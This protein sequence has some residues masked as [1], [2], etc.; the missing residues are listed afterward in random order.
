MTISRTSFLQRI[1]KYCADSERCTHDVLTKLEA[2]GITSDESDDILKKLY[3]EKFVNDRRYA[4]SYVEEKWN[5]DRWG[6]IKIA[7]ALQQKNL[8]EKIIHDALN[9]IDDEEYIQGL[10]EL[11]LDKLKEAK[12]GNMMEDGRRILMFALS[13][14]FEEELIQEWLVKEGFEL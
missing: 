10:H 13:R 4:A 1:M 5:L 14:G 3:K 12:S 9:K 6:K 8:D 2:W 7:H 11:L